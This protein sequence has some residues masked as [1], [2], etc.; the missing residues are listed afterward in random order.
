MAKKQDTAQE[1][2]ISDDKRRFE[3]FNASKLSARVCGQDVEVLDISLG[4]MKL[5]SYVG[6]ALGPVDV[7]LTSVGLK[8]AK[9]TTIVV[10]SVVRA[11]R[12]VVTL[13]LS[14][15]NSELAN[16]VI[17]QAASHYGVKPF[18]FKG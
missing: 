4:G 2:Q 11:D 1:T 12:K 3:R 9:E 6:A 8:G 5:G 14:E 17:R 7:E 18:L 10:A 15:S 16:F 13:E